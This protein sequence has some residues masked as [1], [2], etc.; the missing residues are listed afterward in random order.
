MPLTLEE[1][2]A[3]I[4]TTIPKPR[5]ITKM[6]VKSECS[7][8]TFHWQGRTFLVRTSLQVFELK[9]KSLFVTGASTLAQAVLMRKT[10][11]EKV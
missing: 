7:A 8:V 10:S 4:S 5:S 2:P 11:Q 1:L 9:G 3:Y 6:E